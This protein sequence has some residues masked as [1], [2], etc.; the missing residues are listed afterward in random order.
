MQLSKSATFALLVSIVVSFLAG[1]SAPTPL[2]SLYQAL[3]GFSPI[4]TTVIFGI[5]AVAVL[6]ALLIAGS[7]SDYVGRRP[8]LLAATLVQAITMILFTTAH[9]VGQL[10]LARI[11]QGVAAGA[12]VSA[13]GAGLLDLDR[14]RGTIANSLAPMTG[15]ALGSLLAGILLRYLPAP[16]HLV[17]D[18][19]LGVF[20]LQAIGVL[21]MPETASSKEGALA[22]LRPRLHIPPAARN[23]VLLAAPALIAVWALAG[24]YGSLG[25]TLVRHLAGGGSALFAGLPLFVLAAHGVV[26]VWLLRSLSARAS[27]QLGML[28]L[29]VGVATSL[30]ALTEGSLLEFLLGSAIAGLGFGG[31]FQGA[32]RSVL[33]LAQVHERAGLLSVVYV[34]SYLAMGVP[35]VLAGTLVVYGGGLLSTA[36]EYGLVVMALAAMALLGARAHRTVHTA[37]SAT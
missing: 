14:A 6:S 9:G 3:W 26:G 30:A 36:R 33:P 13:V 7:L 11:V 34:I 2:Y 32:I 22:S 27:T 18:L 20:L 19:L 24:L 16:L 17:Y 5:Y 1:S 35:A 8:V 25:P 31:G 15:T 28:A 29:F 10:I 12:A 37:I 4:T 23:A 21:L